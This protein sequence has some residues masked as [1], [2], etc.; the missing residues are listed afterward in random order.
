[1]TFKEVVRFFKELVHLSQ[2]NKEVHLLIKK[3]CFVWK[4]ILLKYI[5]QKLR[6]TKR[7]RQKHVSSK[8]MPH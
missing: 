4:N 7:N 2:G 3:E 5:K 6:N 8:R 1:M